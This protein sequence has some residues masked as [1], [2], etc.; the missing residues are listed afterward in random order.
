MR[1]ITSSKMY[2]GENAVPVR[3]MLEDR[4]LKT[5]SYSLSA[6]GLSAPEMAVHGVCCFVI[7]STRLLTSGSRR[8]NPDCQHT[9]QLYGAFDCWQILAALRY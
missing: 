4:T 5:T 1:N 7:V 8:I 6:H 2:Q 3:S 9:F